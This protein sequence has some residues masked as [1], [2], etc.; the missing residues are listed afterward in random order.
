MAVKFQIRRDAASNWS[1]TNPILASGEIGFETDTGKLKIGNQ[2]NTWTTLNYVAGGIADFDVV[3]NVSSAIISSGINHIR[4]SG[5]YAKGDGGG[6]LYSKISTP[7]PAKKQHIQSADGQYWELEKFSDLNVLQFGAKKD[8]TDATTTLAA[9][10][11]AA[12]FSKCIHVPTGTYAINGSI[13][14][15][16]NG[17]KW[18]GDG[19]DS[20]VITSS[21]TNTPIFLISAG[22]NGIVIEQMKLTRSVTA[23]DG[24][25]G[26][27]CGLKSIGQSRFNDLIIEKQYDG[28]YLGSTDYS[29]LSNIILQN[30]IRHGMIIVNGQ[31]MAL[32]WQ[33]QNVLAQFNGENG[34][35]I[36]PVAGPSEAV[37]FSQSGTDILGTH[38]TDLPE[39]LNDPYTVVKF[40]TTGSLPGGLT[41]GVNYWVRR[42][43]ATTSKYATSLTNA[44]TNTFVQWQ[45]TGNSGTHTYYTQNLP[46]Q[47]T[48]GQWNRVATYLNGVYGA[49]F[50]GLDNGNVNIPCQGIRLFESFFGDDVTGGVYLDTKNGDQHKIADT[51]FE[52]SANSGLIVAPGNKTVLLTGCHAFG[53]KKDGYYLSGTEHYVVNCR[54]MNNGT[55]AAASNRNG[56]NLVAGRANIVGGRYGNSPD[57]ATQ[58]NGID[59]YDGAN[60]IVT[61]A[62]LTNP[63]PTGNSINCATNSASLTSIGNFPL[64]LQTKIVSSNSIS[65]STVTSERVRIKENGQLRFIPLSSDPSGAEDGD[66]YYNS[67]FNRLRIRANNAWSNIAIS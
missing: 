53:N 6:A 17:A 55:N 11:D 1:S 31:Y 41:S 26:I 20:S 37:T 10:Q 39:A 16:L 9:F 57:N 35:Y 32:Q 3:S 25:R 33:L 43:S 4:T 56:L 14:I 7:V 58:I 23:V 2:S 44:S 60:T 65:L 38:A 47:L 13:P 49:A 54:A 48:L 63:A 40:T 29:F 66:V 61:G 28:M 62:D 50:V 36:F 30:N 59:T 64:T 15:T 5:Y 45:G 27:D 34:F 46:G 18:Y 67:T 21:S 8:G 19:A 24:A 52:L 12:T 22:L 51:F 42:Q